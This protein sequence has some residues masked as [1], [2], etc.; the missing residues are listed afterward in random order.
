[1]VVLVALAACSSPPKA[2]VRKPA[3]PDVDPEGPHADAVAQQVRPFVAGELVSGLVVGLYDAGKLEIYGFGKGPG[4]KP[5]NGRTLFDL[6]SITKVYTN[7]LLADAVQ[8]KLVELD[9]PVS[10]LLPPGVTVPTANQTPITLRHLALHSSGLPRMPPS[11]VLRKTPPDPYASYS[12]DA[13]YQDLI[14]TQLDAP[15]GTRIVYSNYGTGLLGVALGRKLG[16]GYAQALATRVLA[17]LGLRDTS[18]TVP[19]GAASRKAL[20]TDD[21]LQPTSRWTWGALAAAGG[22]ISS[23][24][25]QL[26]LIDAELDAAAG[27][28]GTLR[29]Q[30]RLTQETQLE[31]TTTDNAGLGWT[32]DSAGRYL[33]SGGSGGFRSFI[34][35]DPK[36]KRGVV[37]LASSYTTLVDFL[38]TAMFDVLERTAKPP[39]PVPDEKLLALY[40]GTYDFSGTKLAVVASG[41]RLYLEGPGEPR[42]RMAPFGGEHT[43]WIEALQSAARFDVTGGVVKSVQFKIGNNVVVAPR[44]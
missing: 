36:T 5:P 13:L 30:L 28:K 3:G 38:G 27:S 26:A 43:F 22:L 10:E 14:V 41:K 39:P 11:L 6:G 25:D 12:E 20:G 32:I 29:A 31:G 1:M 9:E 4:G 2:T 23:A 42:H 16:G 7:L 19:A 21:D 17:P 34:G 8:A 37:V 40:A 44:V 35:F 15:P 33:H 18:F 24:R